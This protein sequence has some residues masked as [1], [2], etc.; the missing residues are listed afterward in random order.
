MLQD[1]IPFAKLGEYFPIHASG[2]IV[3]DAPTGTLSSWRIGTK[4]LGG[5]AT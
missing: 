5:F 3:Y 1:T 4:T 2:L